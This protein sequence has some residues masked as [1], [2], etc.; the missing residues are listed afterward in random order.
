M[1]SLFGG[2]KPAFWHTPILMRLNLPGEKAK[3]GDDD[4]AQNNSVP[5]KH[6]EII[7]LDIIKQK[8]D[9]NVGN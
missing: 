1:P 6:L 4:N 8:A 3:I 7:V 9:G 5:A 2:S